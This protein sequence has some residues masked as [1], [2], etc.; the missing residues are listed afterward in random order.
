MSTITELLEAVKNVMTKPDTYKKGDEFEDYVQKVL[1]PDSHFVLVQKTH[2]YIA[3]KNRYIESLKEPDF[4][5]RTRAKYKEF[6]VE[7][8]YRS[9]FHNGVIDWCKPF[10]LRRYQTIDNKIPVYIAVGIGGQPEAPYQ[11]SLIPMTHIRFC[12]L[13][14]SILEKF[15]ISTGYCITEKELF[16]IS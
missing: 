3:N 15:R 13:Y 14:P 8:K 12:R 4:K 10:Q 7:A 2:D 16:M 1:F 6:Y 11:I 9:G 5:F